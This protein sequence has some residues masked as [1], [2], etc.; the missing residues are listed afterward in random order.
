MSIVTKL[1]PDPGDGE[2][3]FVD[4]VIDQW[5]AAVRE[6]QLVFGPLLLARGGSNF[7]WVYTLLRRQ[8]DRKQDPHN[9][10]HRLSHLQISQH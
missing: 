9:A 1:L 2:G 10:T 4:Y 8:L 7:I 5:V 6:R 3:A